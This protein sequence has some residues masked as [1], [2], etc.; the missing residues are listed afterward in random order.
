MA[1]ALVAST[2]ALAKILGV[3]TEAV[4][5]AELRGKIT[6]EPDG[7]WDAVGALASW[8]GYTSAALQRPDRAPEWRPWLCPAIPLHDFVWDE[9]C[10]RCDR[11]GA[12]WTR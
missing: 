5:K 1:R 12:R 3:S 2:A 10:R 6:R 8:R 9:F 4:R 7:C 11:A